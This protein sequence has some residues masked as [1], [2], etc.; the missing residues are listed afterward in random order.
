MYL[1]RKNLILSLIA[2]FVFTSNLIG[3]HNQG[4]L[5][6]IYQNLLNSGSVYEWEAKTISFQNKGMNIVGILTVPKVAKPCPIILILHGFGGDKYGFPVAGTGEGYFDRLARKLAE[7]GFCSLRID[8]RGSGQSDGTFDV[9]SFTGQHSDAI[10]ALDF[11]KTLKNTVKISK[12]GVLGHSQGGLV[13]SMTAAS[14]KRVDSLV[15]WAATGYPPHD[16]EGLFEKS[17]IKQGMALPDGGSAV[18]PLYIDGVYILSLP[19]GKQFFVDLFNEDPLVAVSKFKNPMMYVSPLQDAIVWPQP[20]VGN[21]FLTHHEGYEKLVTVD[22]DHNYNYLVG[23]EQLDITINWTIAWF[24][25]TL[26]N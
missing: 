2:I 25:Q 8:F 17:G 21:A 22:A 18:F 26:G 14:D 3:S 19:I 5:D 12:I 6:Q 24:I 13:A 1:K 10:A 23:P 16:F 4:N 9:T 15:L 20:N 11:I 7:Q